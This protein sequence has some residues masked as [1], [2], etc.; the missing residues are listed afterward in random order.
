METN[1]IY[2]IEGL[3]FMLCFWWVAYTIDRICN[4]NNDWTP[5]NKNIWD[6]TLQVMNIGKHKY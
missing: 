5:K 6:F 3:L 2:F 4:R 1:I